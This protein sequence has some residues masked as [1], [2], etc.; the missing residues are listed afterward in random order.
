MK[1]D[2]GLPKPRVLAILTPVARRSSLT[3]LGLFHFDPCGDN[4]SLESK[5][6]L[7]VISRRKDPALLGAA[8]LFV[9][10]VA[11]TDMMQ[12]RCNSEMSSHDWAGRRRVRPAG[13]GR[14]DG[15]A[16]AQASAK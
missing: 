14:V 1:L 3:A 9:A 12:V 10:S 13:G 16:S 7:S 11:A 2:M 5:L 8:L 4:V 15:P 6:L